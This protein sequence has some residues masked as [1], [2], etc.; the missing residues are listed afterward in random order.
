MCKERV[1]FCAKEIPQKIEQ[2]T[3]S[4]DYLYIETRK[5][6]IGDKR[7]VVVIRKRTKMLGNSIEINYKG[8]S[9]DDIPEKL[10]GPVTLN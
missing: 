2:K 7:N 3:E 8:L 10:R 1:H 4:E 5:T 9:K 6:K